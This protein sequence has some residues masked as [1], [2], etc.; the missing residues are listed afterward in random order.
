MLDLRYGKNKDGIIT[1]F[2]FFFYFFKAKQ[3]P[4][5]ELSLFENYSLSSSTLSTKNNRRH[6]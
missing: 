3:H 6:F 5:V 2:G 4:E 1:F